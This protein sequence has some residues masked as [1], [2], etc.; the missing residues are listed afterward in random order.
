MRKKEMTPGTVLPAAG[1]PTEDTESH[2]ELCNGDLEFGAIGCEGVLN[3][4]ARNNK[5]KKIK[6]LRQINAGK[7]NRWLHLL[8]FFFINC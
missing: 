8:I 5:L 3:K 7:K 6:N 2:N 1:Y 4:I